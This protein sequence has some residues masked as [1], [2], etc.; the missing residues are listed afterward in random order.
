MYGHLALPNGAK[1]I[2]RFP[3]LGRQSP[4]KGVVGPR[5][6]HRGRER[7]RLDG[8]RVA[9]AWRR[10]RAVLACR[11]HT[12]VTRD[13]GKRRRAACGGGGVRRGRRRA[14]ESQGHHHTPTLAPL[15]PH[16]SNALPHLLA[17]APQGLIIP[18]IAAVAPEDLYGVCMFCEVFPFAAATPGTAF[19]G[20]QWHRLACRALTTRLVER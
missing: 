4:S 16:N 15:A 5:R 2:M 14:G 1:R 11:R 17:L 19:Y 6:V 9:A 20:G 8:P 3:W 13:G 10:L 12:W 18:G 7:L